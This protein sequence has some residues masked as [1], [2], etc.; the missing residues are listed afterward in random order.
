M[1]A[2]LVAIPPEATGGAP[3]IMGGRPGIGVIKG[4]LKGIGGGIPNGAIGGRVWKGGGTNE[5]L[6]DEDG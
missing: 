1:E 5:G 3:D 4:G 6:D 2:E